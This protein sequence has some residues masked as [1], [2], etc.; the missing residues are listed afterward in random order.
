[1]TRIRNIGPISLKTD[2]AGSLSG[3]NQK[4]AEQQMA[5]ARRE[6]DRILLQSREQQRRRR[7]QPRRSRRHVRRRRQGKK[8]P[9]HGGSPDG[10]DA[11]AVSRRARSS[12]FRP[13][14]QVGGHADPTGG[15]LAH[16]GRHHVE[17]RHAAL[18]P[19]AMSDVNGWPT[20]SCRTR[21][22]R[23]RSRATRTTW[24]VP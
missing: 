23:L 24:A 9:E 12:S 21:T 18:T 11:G 14:W 7:P 2:R 19:A 4:A 3:P 10:R 1:M 22:S 17:P 6:R 8:R 16:D 13:R 15:I 5:R 20:Y